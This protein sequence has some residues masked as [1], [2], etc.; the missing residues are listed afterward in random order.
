[1]KVENL[2]VRPL[3]PPGGAH[4]VHTDP[5][6]GRIDGL[7]VIHRLRLD[8]SGVLQLIERHFTY[9]PHKVYVIEPP[10]SQLLLFIHGLGG[11]QVRIWSRFLELIH[12]DSK[13][14]RTRGCQF[15]GFFNGFF[16]T[17]WRSAPSPAPNFHR[18]EQ[19]WISLSSLPFVS[20]KPGD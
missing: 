9:E 10:D 14:S 13:L 1:M 7:V 8:R 20:A 3:F 2:T 11:H 15:F 4:M 5:N 12:T 17:T 18:S 16:A 6:H 19:L